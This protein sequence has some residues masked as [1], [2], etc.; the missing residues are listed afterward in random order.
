MIH[1]LITRFA[2]PYLEASPSGWFEERCDLFEKYTLPSIESQ[3]NQ[4]FYWILL[5]NP[6]FPGMDK[7]RLESYAADVLW[8]DWKWDERFEF[9]GERLKAHF[10][11]NDWMITSRIDNDDMIS[12]YFIERCKEA[13]TEDVQWLSFPSGY[14]LKDGAVYSRFYPAS[15]FVSFVEK[16]DSP[17]TVYHTAHTNAGANFP[18]V[19]VTQQPSWIQVDHG[20]N[21]KNSVERLI[22]RG[23]ISSKAVSR[24]DQIRKEFGY[25]NS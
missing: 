10:L 24:F 12:K 21:V 7:D 13:A 1:F 6:D 4:D 5:A 11:V 25:E 20:G 17:L 16:S 22:R 2:I 8:V 9:L 18:I 14:I 15:P 19:E 23:K 3:T